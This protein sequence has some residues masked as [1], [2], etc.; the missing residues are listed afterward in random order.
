MGSVI[1]IQMFD[2]RVDHVLDPLLHLIWPN[3]KLVPLEY[4]VGYDCPKEVVP[5]RLIFVTSRRGIAIGSRMITAR[6]I[7]NLRR[8]VI[9]LLHLFAIRR[10]LA[11]ASVAMVYYLVLFMKMEGMIPSSSSPSSSSS[12]SSSYKSVIKGGVLNIGRFG[13]VNYLG[14]DGIVVVIRHRINANYAIAIGGASFE[15][16][17]DRE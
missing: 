9:V 14:I 3:P 7:I 2:T 15:G 13:I 8:R 5:T 11:I 1:P 6:L 10:F 12:S 17:D 16:A 4:P